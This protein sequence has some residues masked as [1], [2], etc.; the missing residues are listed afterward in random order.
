MRFHP[1]SRRRWTVASRPLEEAGQ[2]STPEHQLA[3]ETEAFLRGTL[4]ELLARQLRT[5]PPWLLVNRPA[6]ATVAELRRLVEGKAAP[7][8]IVAAPP[9]YRGAWMMAERSVVLH[10]LA[11]VG[12]DD[13]LRRLQR[14]VLVPLE[15][16]LVDRSTTE[17]LTLGA[18]VAEVIEAL[19]HRHL[20]R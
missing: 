11:T 19:D 17:S 15:L 8:V 16:D 6:H 10:L 12:G 18:I 13:E 4:A 2:P 20:D 1:F 7:V 5:L 9:G 3:E 14:E